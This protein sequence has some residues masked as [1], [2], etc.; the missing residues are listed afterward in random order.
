ME[1]LN[2]GSLEGVIS[3]Q[4]VLNRYQQHKGHGH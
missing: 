3:L 4:D 2:S 1:L